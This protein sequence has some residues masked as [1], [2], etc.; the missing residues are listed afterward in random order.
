M[1]LLITQQPWWIC[2]N[3]AQLFPFSHPLPD[4]V[5]IFTPWH[6]QSQELIA[7][8][9]SARLWIEDLRILTKYVHTYIRMWWVTFRNVAR[10]VITY[11]NMY[12]PYVRHTVLHIQICLTQIHVNVI[13]RGRWHSLAIVECPRVAITPQRWLYQSWA[14]LGFLPLR[15]PRSPTNHW[16]CAS[17]RGN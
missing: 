3:P 11:H 14:L 8:H 1:K 13:D 10:S 15:Y 17:L 12:R 16:L 4:G 9:I 2:E 6:P 5:P 7:E